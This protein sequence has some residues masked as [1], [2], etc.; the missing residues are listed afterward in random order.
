MRKAIGGVKENDRGIKCFILLPSRP[1]LSLNS[2]TPPYS[3]CSLSSLC[4]LKSLDTLRALNARQTHSSCPTNSPKLLQTKRRQ[5]SAGYIYSSKCGS[6]AGLRERRYF[7]P[8][9][10]LTESGKNGRGGRMEEQLERLRMWRKTRGG[11]MHKGKIFSD[12]GR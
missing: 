4:L 6:S 2:S 12:P 9:S 11:T 1:P 8:L 3:V 7:W 10:G 5:M